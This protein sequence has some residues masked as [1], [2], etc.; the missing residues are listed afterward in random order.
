VKYIIHSIIFICLSVGLEA[1]DQRALTEHPPWGAR[2][3]GFCK[4]DGRI[5]VFRSSPSVSKKQWAIWEKNV[6]KIEGYQKITHLFVNHCRLSEEE[7][8]YL[9][10]FPNIESLILGHSIEG[11]LVSPES[12]TYLKG[13]KN[14]REIS[15]SIHGVNDSHFREISKIQNLRKISMDYPSKHMIKKSELEYWEKIHISDDALDA[16]Q[17]IQNLRSLSL[18]YFPGENEMGK[19][20]FSLNSL[21]KL[22]NL[23]EL[24][25]ICFNEMTFS[26]VKS[27][28]G[29]NI[30]EWRYEVVPKVRPINNH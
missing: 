26:K 23:P 5:T 11:V 8:S 15:F 29:Q 25:K 17:K 24:D 12:L 4:D 19:V 20:V 7:M 16:V 28:N 9:C 13:L 10:H 1:G 30:F 27:L 2:D 18:R 6:T 21:E 14:L 3:S 22:F